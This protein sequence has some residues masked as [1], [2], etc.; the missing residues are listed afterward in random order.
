MK[1]NQQD[2]IMIDLHHSRNLAARPRAG[3]FLALFLLA[4]LLAAS[5]PAQ[6]FTTLH[7]FNSDG[8]SPDAGLIL[9]GNTLYGTTFGEE[10]E[11]F[12]G[13]YVFGTLFAIHTDGT[14]FTN[15]YGNFYEYN[16]GPVD[17]LALSGNTLYGTTSGGNV[18][19]P[20][21]LFSV[22]TNGTGFTNNT[23]YTGE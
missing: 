11:G 16:T 10:N 22:N 6:T 17:G 15:V 13:G 18:G 9:S 8:G 20:Y 3:C 23:Y 7:S 21:T 14:G 4:G 1:F 19:G 2:T 12:S 5:A